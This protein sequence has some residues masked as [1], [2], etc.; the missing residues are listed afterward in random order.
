MSYSDEYIKSLMRE[1]FYCLEP[2]THFYNVFKSFQ[3]TKKKSRVFLKS[4]PASICLKWVKERETLHC[5]SWGK[6]TFFCSNKLNLCSRSIYIYMMF[7]MKS[8]KK[9]DV[10]KDRFL[11]GKKLQWIL[12]LDFHHH[13]RQNKQTE[14]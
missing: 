11:K 14:L 13:W 9:S 3:A 12:F 10:Y 5:I 6:T 1:Y 4:F 2:Q 7:T 8:D